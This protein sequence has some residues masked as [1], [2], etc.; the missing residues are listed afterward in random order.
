MSERIRQFPI[1]LCNL[2][3]TQGALP[4]SLWASHV[5][6]P[7]GEPRNTTVP[8]SLSPP[9]LRQSHCPNMLPAVVINT[10]WPQVSCGI[11]ALLGL[12]ISTACSMKGSQSRN[13]GR[14]HR[15]TLLTAVLP[16]NSSANFPIGLTRT[17]HHFPKVGTAHSRLGPPTS[18]IHQDSVPPPPE[19][20]Q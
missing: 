2:T 6:G 8:Y 15:T 14:R 10:W 11:E 17:Q 9:N 12:S 4:K 3:V 19:A 16:R 13:P 5:C 18:T 20:C 1:S 7:C